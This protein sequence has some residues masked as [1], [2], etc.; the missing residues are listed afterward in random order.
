MQSRFA[1]IRSAQHVLVALGALTAVFVGGQAQA[2]TTTNTLAIS[3]QVLASCTIA[4]TTAVAFGAYDSAADKNAE[5]ALVV[6]CTPGTV[7]NIALSTG[8]NAVGGARYL[9]AGGA[10]RLAYNLYTDQARTTAWSDITQAGVAHTGTGTN[11]SISVYGRIGSGQTAQPGNYV[12]T[13]TA[14]MEF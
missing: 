1:H 12:D 6:N 3:A 14:T 4:S 10:D 2:A 7:G 5:G 13:V 9:S 11:A 8:G